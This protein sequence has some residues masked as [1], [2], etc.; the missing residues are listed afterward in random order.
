MR[1]NRLCRCV[2]ISCRLFG[3][4]ECV[5]RIVPTKYDR[6]HA[7][8]DAP[9]KRFCTGQWVSLAGASETTAE[10]VVVLIERRNT[11]SQTRS[12]SSVFE[13]T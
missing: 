3:C 13:K 11:G 2:G 1:Q 4:A 6:H 10:S 9:A 7:Y 8:V 12:A 5:T